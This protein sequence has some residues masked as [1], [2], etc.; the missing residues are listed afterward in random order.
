MRVAIDAC[1]E[2]MRRMHEHA[3]PGMTENEVWAMLHAANIVRGGEWIETRLLAS[4]PRTNPWFQ[5]CGHRV[6]ESGDLVSYDTDLIGPYGYCADLSRSFVCGARP[7]KAQRSLYAIALEQI[8]FNSSLL[9]PGLSFDD[10]ARQS[11]VLPEGYRRGHYSCIAHGIGLCDEHPLIP[12][13]EDA[14]RGAS[15]GEFEPG[16]TVC[17]ESY[18]GADDG[19]EGVK[20]EQQVLITQSGAELL[21]DFPLDEDLRDASG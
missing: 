20:L 11:F 10:F 19:G 21:S 18:V 17:V 3:R 15:D 14:D 6:I 12:Y 9:R 4:G 7:T 13:P 2:G 16:M 8:R 1:Q 5:E